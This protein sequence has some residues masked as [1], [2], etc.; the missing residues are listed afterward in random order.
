MRFGFWRTCRVC[1]RWCRL[2]LLLLLLAAACGLLWFNQI[3]LPAFLK[4]PLLANLQQR[5]IQVAF[6]RMRLRMT[7]GIV[8]ENV[9][10]GDARNPDRPSLSVREVQLLLDF[11]SLLRGRLGVE[12][13]VLREGRLVVPV[14]GAAPP[15]SP[16]ELTNIQTDLRF[17]DNDTWSLD[18]F[19]AGF[20]GA[21][22]TLTGDVAHAPEI[23]QWE[24]FRGQT[25]AGPYN[26][27]AEVQSV[28]D[29]LQ[30]LHL[31][32]PAVLALNIE[33]DARKPNSFGVWLRVSAPAVRTPWFS[34]RNLKFNAQLTA[35]TAAFTSRVLP[36]LWS[37]AQPWRL[38]WSAQGNQ[39]EADPITADSVTA[40]GLWHTPD[41]T[42][43][44]RL[45]T[46]TLTRRRQA[47]AVQDLQVSARLTAP[48]GSPARRVWPGLSSN[49]QPARI[50][51]SVHGLGLKSAAFRAEALSA[52][53]SWQNQGLWL[54]ARL[55][56]AILTNQ[57]QWFAAQDLQVTAQLTPEDAP[58][59]PGLPGVWS[60]ALPWRL[61]WSTRGN[62]LQS[63]ALNVDSLAASGIWRAPQLAVTNLSVRLGHGGLAG[64][65]Q[66]DAAR[67]QL[68]FTNASQFDLSAVAALL[69]EI[70]RQ[71]LA[72]FTWSRPPVLQCGGTVD[73]SAWPPA[74]GEPEAPPPRASLNGGFTFT[75]ASVAGLA[76]DRAASHFSYSNQVWQLP[77]LQVEHETTR[78]RLAGTEDET[79]K[80]FGLQI[81]GELDL[82]QLRPWVKGPVAVR[83]LGRLTFHQ[84]LGLDLEVHGQLHDANTLAASGQ[85]ALTNFSVRGGPVDRLTTGLS[86]T[87]RVFQF[88]HT[89]A[90]RGRGTQILTADQ[91]TLD[92]N[93]YRIYFTNG[94][95]TAEPQVV[96]DS[97]G[98]KTG[99]TLEPYQFLTPPTARVN[100]YVS[101]HSSE[102][103]SDLE[104][105]DLQVDI[106]RGAPF[107]WLKFNTPGLAGTAH[108]FGG[109]LLLTNL[110]ADFYGGNATGAMLFDFRPHNGTDYAF[111]FDVTDASLHQ[112]ITELANPT[113]HLRGA[114]GGRLVVTH[115]NSTD[116]RLMDGYGHASLRD[117]LIWEAPVFGIFSPV[118]NSIDP[119]LG[120][121]R[122]TE[123]TARFTMT[124]GVIHSDSLEIHT[125]MVRLQYNG[126]VDMN[127]NLNAR[128]TAQPLRDTWGLGPILNTVIFPF[129][130]LFEYR[131]TGTLADPQ[132]TELNDLAK[133]ILAPLHPLK[134]L[135][136]ILPAGNTNAPPRN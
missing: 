37:N 107:R 2:S 85:L 116:W 8:A 46:A 80:L 19:Q 11:G 131:V 27:P 44:L 126:T 117:G 26:W 56:T 98:P 41:F 112:M 108:W 39:L 99:R 104:E 111:A 31:H 25:T 43:D 62:G 88:F 106:V 110:N 118:L 86:Y 81:R 91:I 3:G 64:R 13:L 115:A 60:N 32:G 4:A 103:S 42:F 87:N 50:T 1:V 6:T 5:G 20:R 33:G 72:L 74:A 136:T 21:R 34:A 79:T 45:Q 22:L 96:A 83:E 30:N 58:A 94:F 63:S 70:T 92:L 68:T 130:K 128:V 95:S 105:A 133:L 109:T 15:R 82:N 36:G 120:S 125:T 40:R 71:R 29:V 9:R 122:A 47:F 124:N 38:A 73:L 65:I 59:P 77:D 102:G 129:S 127:E 10:V 54:D 16:L 61:D 84:P 97:I 67:R 18:N 53:G 7:R 135:K 51:G 76:L 93:Q 48:D 52:S 69:P 57:P 100:G 101:L 35:P 134:S 114:I 17:H 49:A 132:S 90:R 28:S 121:S 75:N 24:V 14:T 66:F 119:G 55:Q 78:L 113:N 123:A 12:G 89:D 23:L